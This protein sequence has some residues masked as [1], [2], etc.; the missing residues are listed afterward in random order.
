LEQRLAQPALAPT[1]IASGGRQLK[2]VTEGTA[3][4]EGQWLDLWG[5]LQALEQEAQ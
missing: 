2:A 4:L 3:W 5:Q 1:D